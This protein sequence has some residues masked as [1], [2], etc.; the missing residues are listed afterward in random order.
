MALLNE[1]YI[2]DTQAFP[3]NQVGYDYMTDA[4]IALSDEQLTELGLRVVV[5]TDAP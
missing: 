3:K 4:P 1:P 5:E 2:R